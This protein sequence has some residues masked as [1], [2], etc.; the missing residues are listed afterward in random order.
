MISFNPVEKFENMYFC[1]R[2]PG[3]TAFDLARDVKMKK[4]LDVQPSQVLCA[5][6]RSFT[7][8]HITIQQACIQQAENEYPC[9]NRLLHRAILTTFCTI[10]IVL[11][12]LLN[13]HLRNKYSSYCRIFHFRLY[14]SVFKAI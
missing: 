11:S 14:I 6:S 12:N 4:L 7:L 9:Y 3:Q 13:A 2:F 1:F 10:I 5:I 8:L